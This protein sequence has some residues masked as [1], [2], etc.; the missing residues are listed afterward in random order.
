MPNT[1]LGQAVASMNAGNSPLNQ[2][3]NSAPTF[4]AGLQAPTPVPTPNQSPMSAVPNTSLQK[5]LQ[6]RGVQLPQQPQM[7]NQGVGEVT[8]P[9]GM[10]QDTNKAQPGTQIPTTEAE[11]IIKALASRLGLIGKKET[12][13]LQNTDIGSNMPPTAQ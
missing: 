5:S 8:V 11:L 1:I 7:Q 6:Q 12:A 9:N 13:S 4:N 10:G 3:S 2:V